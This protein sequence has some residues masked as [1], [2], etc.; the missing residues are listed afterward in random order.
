MTKI[1]YVHG[2]GNPSAGESYD[3]MGRTIIEAA[4]GRA[5]QSDWRECYWADITQPDQ[6]ALFTLIGR[7]GL[8]HSYL[9]TSLGDIVA[10]CRPEHF[11]NKYDEIQQRFVDSVNWCRDNSDPN[12]QTPLIV[13]GKSL[14]SVIASDGLWEMLRA[15]SFPAN[16]VLHAFFTL[17]SPMALFALRFGLSNFN[18]P[19]T[20]QVW[21]NYYYD[22]DP[23]GFPLKSLPG[24]TSVV[25]RDELLSPGTLMRQI[26]ATI[27]GLNI[28]SHDWYLDDPR[29]INE[30]AS[31]L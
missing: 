2:M 19:I 9:F 31:H 15:G 22:P 6:D 14:G 7:N 17:G 12:G 13:I 16:L 29:V 1:I 20:P 21:I 28:R 23:I 4:Q 27:P 8:F 25:T 24:Y 3:L 18:Q 10:Y 30:I 11:P 5:S 26:V